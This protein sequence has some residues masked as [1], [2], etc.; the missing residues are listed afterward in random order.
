MYTK[1]RPG[2]SRRARGFR[3]SLR[4]MR[5]GLGGW[6]RCR[7][8]LALCALFGSG[9]G[10]CGDDEAS[11]GADFGLDAGR[12]D[13]SIDSGMDGGRMDGGELED[14]GPP[15][16]SAAPDSELPDSAEPGPDAAPDAMTPSIPPMHLGETGLY[17]QGSLSELAQGVMPYTPHYVLWSDG[18][19]KQRYLFLPEGETIDTSDPDAFVFPIG[20]KAWKEFSLEGKRLETRLLWKTDNG[21]IHVAYAWNEAQDDAIATTRGAANV[22]GTEHD[23]P[24]RAQCRDCHRG[25]ADVL[26]GVSA[27]QLAHGG[28]GLTLSELEAQGWLSDPMPADIERPDSLE[29]NALGYLHANCGNCH[30]PRGIGFD[31]VDMDLWL[32]TGQ[33]DLASQTQ[34]YLTTVGVPPEQTAGDDTARIE[35]GASGDSALI[36]RMKLRDDEQAM[37]PIASEIIDDAGIGLVEEWIDSLSIR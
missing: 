20:T 13:G 33:L 9:L 24:Q 15:R 27:V 14:S 18:A 29:W 26:L 10:A 37:P 30:N 7:V 21:W 35:P 2:L 16:D 19:D 8:V 12:V 11:P 36:T 5:L 32:R 28:D 31:R 25:S 23:I 6:S 22:L 4:A 1:N 3:C 34:S 17:V